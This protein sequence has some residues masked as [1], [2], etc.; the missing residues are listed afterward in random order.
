M[1]HARGAVSERASWLGETN[2]KGSW[3]E[4]YERGSHMWAKPY[5]N[6][7]Q[8]RFHSKTSGKSF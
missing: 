7:F 8:L 6:G 4:W 1:F 3:G 5:D 2:E